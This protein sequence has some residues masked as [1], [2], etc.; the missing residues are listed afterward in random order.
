MSKNLPKGWV[1]CPLSALGK[2]GTGGTPS[3][4]IKKYFQGS[5]PWV[6]TGDLGKK[7]LCDTPEKISEEAIN[8]SNAKIF[9]KG[10][11]AIAMYGAT[12]GKT[13]VFEIPAATNQACAVLFPNGTVHSPEFI[14]Y[15][16]CNEKK[17]IVNKSKG[18]AQPNVSQTIIKEHLISL[19]PLN[20][21]KRIVAKLDRLLTHVDAARSRLDS[22]AKTI[23][24][25]RQSVLNAAVTGKLFCHTKNIFNCKTEKIGEYSLPIIPESWNWQ[26]FNEVAKIESNL[27]SPLDFP[28]L[29]H[30]AP[31]HIESKTGRL[32]SYKTIK[33]DKVKSPKHFF[34]PGMIL[35]SKIRP[36]LCKAIYVEFE[37]L[38]SADMYPV[39]TNQNV[40]FL[41][42]WM[43]SSAFT[44]FASKNQAR[45]V[46]PKINQKALNNLPV[47]IPP[48]PEQ[49]EIVKRVEALFKL[50]DSME[51]RLEEARKRVETLT[52]SIL[53]K[54]FRGELVPQNPNDQ[55]AAEL[56]QEIKAAAE[57]EKANKKAKKRKK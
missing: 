16:L 39:S 15:L 49:K 5:I 56:L 9:P 26:L 20:E 44:Y 24:R 54:A 23:K 22:A 10:S 43:I 36:Y 17:K 31:N 2:W 33:E 32:L 11:I 7:Y 29:P 38:C 18:G 12:I 1:E 8:N 57:S 52:A 30:I 4:R 46:L 47:P 40:K 3:R 37:G 48:L 25:F 41:H 14:F 55:P 27:K 42:L 13:S 51:A 53:A 45:V 50:A 19:P 35:Y 28:D 21:Q 34:S 6:K